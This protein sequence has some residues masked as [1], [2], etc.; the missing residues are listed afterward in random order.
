MNFEKSDSKGNLAKNQPSQFGEKGP[1]LPFV[2]TE[3]Q[4]NIILQ[5]L[6]PLRSLVEGNRL[7]VNVSGIPLRIGTGVLCGRPSSNE[8]A[9]VKELKP[10]RSDSDDVIRIAVY[11]PEVDVIQEILANGYSQSARIKLR[12]PDLVVEAFRFEDHTPELKKLN[13]IRTGRILEYTV[14]RS[15]LLDGVAPILASFVKCIA[16]KFDIGGI[17]LNAQDALHLALGGLLGSSLAN[18]TDHVID[19]V[20][21]SQSV[22]HRFNRP[23]LAEIYQITIPL[24]ADQ[25]RLLYSNDPLVRLSGAACAPALAV[26]IREEGQSSDYSQAVLVLRNHLQKYYHSSQSAANR[27]AFDAIRERL[28]FE[29]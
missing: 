4:F 18:A 11:L 22:W 26:V 9:G 20:P 27:D 28:V 6:L 1:S 2:E 8:M 24:G 15:E 16:T 21:S 5:D 7:W 23:E 29:R 12:I 10:I 13:G 19:R 17:E 25:R 14:T 3:L